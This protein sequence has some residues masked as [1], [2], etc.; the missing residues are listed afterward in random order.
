M[1]TKRNWIAVAAAAGILVSAVTGT[2][3]TQRRSRMLVDTGVTRAA[4]E[5]SLRSLLPKTVE[6]ARDPRLIAAVRELE[7]A[8]Y[9]VS[10]WVVAPDGEIVYRRCGPGQLGDK[11]QDL[12]RDDMAPAIAALGPGAFSE[13]QRLQLLAVAAMR[14]EGEHNDVFRHMARAL[15]DAAGGLGAVVVLGYDVSPLVG[16]P[17][18]FLYLSLLLSGLAGFAVY[19]LGLPLW[20]AC[21]ARARGEAAALWAVFVL[22]TNLVGLVAYLIVIWR[23]V[24]RAAPSG[25]L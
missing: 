5:D 23:P 6:S 18:D 10:V 14:R 25:S 3:L 21:D 24:R 2:V 8:L 1:W 19:W 12:A 4:V 15:P 9:V 17:P 11:V 13:T 16:S 22:F 20:V 7:K